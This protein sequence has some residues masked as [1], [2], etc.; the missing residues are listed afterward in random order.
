MEGT[1]QM[2]VIEERREKRPLTDTDTDVESTLSRQKE[3]K[4]KS[5]FL[6]DS[7]EEAIMEFLKQHKELYDKTYGKFKDKQRKEGALGKTSSFQEFICQR[8]Q[9]MVRDSTYQ[10]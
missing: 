6:S 2:E 4:I 7:D 8:C 9:E 1:Q 10:I 5:I 3:G